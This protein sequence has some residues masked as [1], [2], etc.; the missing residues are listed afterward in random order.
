VQK[1][2]RFRF[3]DLA[4]KAVPFKA[5]TTYIWDERTTL[6]LRIGKRTKTFIAMNSNGRRIKIGK[7]P[8]CSLLLARQKHLQLQRDAFLGHTNSS[9][10]ASYA[11]EQYL[12]AQAQKTRAN[13]RAVGCAGEWRDWNYGCVVRRQ[14]CFSDHS[15]RRG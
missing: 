15:D 13:T 10:T 7:Y 8:I 12:E 3:T 11:V 5:H 2:S 14:C 9:Q 4:L 6:G 1:A